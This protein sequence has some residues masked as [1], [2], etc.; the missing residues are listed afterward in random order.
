MLH[1]LPPVRFNFCST[2]P[3]LF[4]AVASDGS[5]SIT[6]KIASRESS[7]LPK[8]IK[9]FAFPVSAF[10]FS[11]LILKTCYSSQVRVYGTAHS[12]ELFPLLF[13]TSAFDG[14]AVTDY[15]SY[16]EHLHTRPVHIASCPSHSR[17]LHRMDLISVDLQ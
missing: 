2:N 11:G 13:Q 5:I 15:Y 3:L 12:R 1:S 16:L 17:L 8:L 14:S 6:L 4:H 10:L 7:Y 9:A